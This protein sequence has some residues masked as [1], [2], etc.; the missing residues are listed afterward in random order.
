MRA[1]QG[2][3]LVHVGRRVPAALRVPL[4]RAAA[5]RDRPCPT[6]SRSARSSSSTA[7]TS[8]ATRPTR[9]STAAR[10]LN[11]DHHHDN[12]RF[13]TVNHVVPDASCTAEVIWDLMR[14]L[15]VELTQ[16][17]AEALYVGLVTDTGKFMYEN[18]GPRAH[19]M[20]AELIDAGDRR[21][22]DLPAA[23]R[24][25]PAGQARAAR[26][27]PLRGRA[28][29]RRAAH[30]DP[31]HARGL[32]GDRRGRELLRGRR[33]PP[34]RARGD[35]G[36]GPRARAASDPPRRAARC[37]CARPTTG[38]TCR[39]SPARTAAAATAARPAS[40]PTSSSPSS[41]RSCARSSPSSFERPT[42]SCSST[43]PPASP[44][45][46][47]SRRSGARAAAASKVGHAG[48]LD[49]F[50]TGLLLVLVGRA[51]R[52]QRFL[53]ALPEALRDG[54]AAGLDVD[55][56]RRRGR[57]R[58]GPHAAR[59]AAAADGPDP[60]APARLLGRQGRRAARVRARARGRG[61]RAARA[62]G[63]RAPLRAAAGATASAP[64]FAIEC[65]SGTYVRSLIADLGDA[66]CL[67][68][69]RTRIGPFDV[70]DAG[71]FVAAG[72]GARLPARG[73]ARRRRRAARRP[74]RRGRRA[75]RGGHR[76]AARRATG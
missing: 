46:T 47:W 70:A 10:I 26:A 66:Y 62:R 64:A 11:I 4:P 27:R 55:D 28:L 56:R 37:R 45:T 8:T 76:A 42:A 68:L 73:R 23:L 3:R 65:G 19:V 61:R 14:G 32:R 60:P 12:T 17:I 72:R 6:T 40:R 20:A 18:T 25:R 34:A 15:G 7:A 21:A 49:P 29:R 69:R 22:R 57:A 48:T 36:R 52:A 41:S 30:A 75:R 63:R 31:A 50:A 44:R 13:G 1:R 39:R 5:A 33:R 9:S 38:S 74:R 59:A 54:R 58:A 43:S 51:T 53:M 16:P 67:E 35:R 2:R 24:G 71:R